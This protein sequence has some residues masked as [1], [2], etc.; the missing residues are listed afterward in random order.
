MAGE[1]GE[2]GCMRGPPAGNAFQRSKQLGLEVSL[3]TKDI[4]I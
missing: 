4:G 3:C 1:P 2:E